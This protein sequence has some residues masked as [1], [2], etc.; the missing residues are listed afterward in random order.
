VQASLGDLVG[1]MFQVG[2]LGT[3]EPANLPSVAGGPAGIVYGPLADMPVD[4]DV[5]V[6]WMT[7]K[8]AMYYD[9]AA[10]TVQWDAPTPARVYGRPGCAAVAMASKGEQP[11]LSMGCIGM[12]TFTEIADDRV[13]VAVPGNRV[14][15]LASALESTMES[16]RVMEAAYRAKAAELTGA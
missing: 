7:P 6:M 14:E 16:N 15:A 11:A 13:L 2:Y 12:R 5:V 9:E 1:T 3:G 10:G 4:P 8:Q